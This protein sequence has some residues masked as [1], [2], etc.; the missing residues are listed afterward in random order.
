MAETFKVAQVQG[1][2]SVGTYATLYNTSASAQA[3]IST[4]AI[5]NTASTAATYRIG[6][7]GSAGTPSASEWLAFGTTV[8][9]NDTIALTLG[10]TLG[11]SQFIRVSSS[12][13][14]VTFSAYVSE[15]T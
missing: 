3:V 7:M 11:N 2:S 10:L 1:T 5:C 8:A 14:T 12:A 15:I 13:N 4:I 6:I 9:A